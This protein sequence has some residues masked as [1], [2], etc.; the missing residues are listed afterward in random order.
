MTVAACGLAAVA[1]IFSACG[2]TGTSPANSQGNTETG[3]QTAVASPSPSAPTAMPHGTT[4]TAPNAE[5]IDTSKYDAEIKRLR[6]E[7]E[8]LSQ[9]YDALS[10]FAST[11]KESKPAAAVEPPKKRKKRVVKRSTSKKKRV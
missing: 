5:A 9:R 10:S 6:A 2:G 1:L 3:A 8:G 11:P 7:L 4:S